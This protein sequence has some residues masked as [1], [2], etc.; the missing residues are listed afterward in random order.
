MCLVLT[1]VS[2]YMEEISQH[3]ST[4]EAVIRRYTVVL[5]KYRK[6]IIYTQQC[7]QL[8]T[9]VPAG[10]QALSLFILPV[11]ARSGIY[12]Y[13][14]YIVR[15]VTVRSG[16]RSASDVPV[17]YTPFILL[18]CIFIFRLVTVR[19]RLEFVLFRPVTVRSGCTFL[20]I[21]W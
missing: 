14:Y 20:H 15:L 2:R 12:I 18:L 5:K 8:F 13:T 21:G 9:N 6:Y 3:T 17:R 16:A 7:A 19:P 11:T 10:S 4:P 1:V